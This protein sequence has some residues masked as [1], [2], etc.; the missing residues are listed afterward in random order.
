M[1]ICK[2]MLSCYCIQYQNIAG[3]TNWHKIST[4]TLFSSHYSLGI[5]VKY[6]GM[7]QNANKQYPSKVCKSHFGMYA[8]RDYSISEKCL[9][10]WIDN[11]STKTVLLHM[12]HTISHGFV[13]QTCTCHLLGFP[14]LPLAQHALVSCSTSDRLSL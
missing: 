2:Q 4:I 7:V 3:Y 11:Q 8:C 13:P 5:T 1:L 10:F 6:L 12:Q 9:K 14:T